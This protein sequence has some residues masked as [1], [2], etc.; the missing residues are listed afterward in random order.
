MS[1]NISEC[2]IDDSLLTNKLGG[3]T[4]NKKV[5]FNDN[6]SLNTEASII[7]SGANDDMFNSDIANALNSSFVG[8][9]SNEIF[10]SPN[11]SLNNDDSYDKN[12]I[13]NTGFYM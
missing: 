7:I 2:I 6:R 4:Q 9:T 10:P 3:K 13:L 11:I 12:D 8:G 5:N 1:I